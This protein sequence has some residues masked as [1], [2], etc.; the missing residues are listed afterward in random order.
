MSEYS[1]AKLPVARDRG[2]PLTPSARAC[3]SLE[4]SHGPT[5]IAKIGTEHACYSKCLVLAV[6]N[7]RSELRRGCDPR[8]TL[9]WPSGWWQLVDLL[10]DE[11]HGRQARCP[12]PPSPALT[13]MYRISLRDLS[14]RLLEMKVCP[15]RAITISALYVALAVHQAVADT[16][17]GRFFI[18][19]GNF[20]PIAFAS[21]MTLVLINKRD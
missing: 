19:A 6:K 9:C 17:V 14:C 10:V 8:C 3:K 16:N 12:T 15:A 11:Q 2:L 18:L 20:L 4:Q 21:G 1:R 5:C 7:E 13:V